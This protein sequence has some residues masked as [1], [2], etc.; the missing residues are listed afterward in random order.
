MRVFGATAVGVTLIS[1]S[2]TERSELPSFVSTILKAAA[3]PPLSAN[4]RRPFDIAHDRLFDI[5]LN[6]LSPSRPAASPASA[7]P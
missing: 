4:S 6:R 5:A 7:Q 3:R 1:D 2:N